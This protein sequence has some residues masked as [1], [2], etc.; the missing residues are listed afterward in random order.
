MKRLLTIFS[1][2]LLL[3]GCIKRP[4]DQVN[5]DSKI[6]V[7]FQWQK[8]NTGDPISESMKLYFYGEDGRIFCKDANSK[9]FSG[10]LPAQKYNVIAINTDAKGVVYENLDDYLTASVVASAVKTKSSEIVEQPERVYGA[11]VGDIIIIGG[12]SSNLVLEPIKYSKTINNKFVISG[13][14]SEL[15]K[16][17][18]FLSG[19]SRGFLLHN[20]ELLTGEADSA[21]VIIDD[22]KKDNFSTSFNVFGIFPNANN[23]LKLNFAFNNGSNESI[24]INVSEVLKK[25]EVAI[26]IT[27]YVDIV[28]EA[29]GG[30]R[31]RLKSWISNSEEIELEKIKEN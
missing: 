28:R 2:T 15:E 6:N 25:V 30:F 21:S 29:E 1:L 23:I 9:G 3:F 11:S 4:L 18:V 14:V 20:S 31:A 5:P 27:V 19:L 22:I 10:T 16:C 8:L 13:D 7:I 26:N 24:D 17:Q 12:Q